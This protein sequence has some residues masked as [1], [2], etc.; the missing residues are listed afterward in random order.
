LDLSKNVLTSEDNLIAGLKPLNKCNFPFLI[1]CNLG[2]IEFYVGKNPYVE[3]DFS[4]MKMKYPD[5]LDLNRRGHKKGFASI[6]VSR[7]I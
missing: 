5:D 4:R 7:R 3:I 2:K 1:D 6:T